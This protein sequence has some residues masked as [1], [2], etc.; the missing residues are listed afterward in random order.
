MPKAL[1]FKIGST[2]TIT[3]D[4]RAT[5]DPSDDTIRDIVTKALYPQFLEVL[6]TNRRIFSSKVTITFKPRREMSLG[7]WKNLFVNTFRNAGYPNAYFTN[8]SRGTE[9]K[10]PG[11]L[12]RGVTGMLQEVGETPIVAEAMSTTKW[13]AIAGVGLALMYFMPRPKWSK[14]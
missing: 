2:A 14:R 3:I 12:L 5:W 8:L 9:S 13:I 11:G 4:P 1:V 6:N 10:D 7:E